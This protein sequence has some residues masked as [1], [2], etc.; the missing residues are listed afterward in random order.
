[1]KIGEALEALKDGRK[2]ARTGWN[3]K[4]MHL[5]LQVP[6]A[7]SK[8]TEPYVYI[9]RVNGFL[10]PWLCSQIDLLAEDWVVV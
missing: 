3:G 6:D 4:G 8:M 1:M 10:V 7:H 5:E 9:T 2:V